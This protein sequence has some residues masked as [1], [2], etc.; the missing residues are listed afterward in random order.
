MRQRDVVADAGGADIRRAAIGRLHDARAAAGRDD[1]VAQFAVVAQSTAALRHDPAELSGHGIIMRM[2]KALFGPFPGLGIF[3][4]G[5]FG[6]RILRR[7]HP[8][9]AEHDDGGAD[10]PIAQQQLCLFIFQREPHAAQLI[11]QEELR[12]LDWED[13]TLRAGLRGGIGHW[14][15]LSTAI[16]SVSV[17]HPQ[18]L[19]VMAGLDPAIHAD[20]R[21]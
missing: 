3:G 8:R 6:L 15:R 9:A 19:L 16:L 4:G 1:V 2:G 17:K 12:V 10:A 21:L 14:G 13:V 20:A 18:A 7:L 11:A 5:Q